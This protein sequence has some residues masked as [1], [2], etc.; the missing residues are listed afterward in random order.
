MG[1]IY[2]MRNLIHTLTYL[3]LEADSGHILP[4]V[5]AA[6]G[7]Y[8]KLIVCGNCLVEYESVQVEWPRQIAI[9]TPMPIKCS[10]VD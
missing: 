3:T 9:G 8:D 2:M 7:K 10:V 5:R 6:R 4:S 1:F